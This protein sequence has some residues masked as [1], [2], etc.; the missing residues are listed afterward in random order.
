[1]NG[2]NLSRFY[3]SNCD[4][5]LWVNPYDL[6]NLNWI[7]RNLTCHN[8]TPSANCNPPTS[9]NSV[10]SEILKLYD[11]VD[12]PL[13]SDLYLQMNGLVPDDDSMVQSCSDSQENVI[14][15]SS[16]LL[17]YARECHIE[18]FQMLQS[19]LSVLL[20]GDGF[21]MGFERTFTTLFGQDVQTF[22]DIMILNLD[23]LRQQLDRE[24]E[25]ERKNGTLRENLEY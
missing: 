2:C 11:M 22:T 20:E 3:Y 21:K 16:K 24:E 23:Q 25:K 17:E 8:Y 4:L 1:V 19:H 5:T 6:T 15:Q 7:Y 10:I 13:T 18:C 14:N 12:V 9:P